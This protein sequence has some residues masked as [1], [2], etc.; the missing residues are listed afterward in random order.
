MF[1]IIPTNIPGLSAIEFTLRADSRGFFVKTMHAD[2]FGEAGIV[3]DFRESYY[4]LSK[5]NVLRGFHFQTPPAD[6]D[7]FVYCVDGCVL[8]VVV[9]LRRNSQTYGRCEAR[10]LDGA[11]PSGFII[12]KGCGHAF[13]TLSDRAMLVYNVTSVYAPAQDCGVAW[14]SVDFDWP[15]SS[16]L[17]SDR[18]R[19]FP[20]LVDFK[21]PF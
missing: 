1:N 17:V 21:T 19:F 15:I 18:D 8:D 4:S 14:N 3:F 20:K 9:D 5:K 16:P 2:A 13:L 6:H 10:E 12:P 11:S 7:K